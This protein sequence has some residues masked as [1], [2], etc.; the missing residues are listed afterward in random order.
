MPET[1]RIRTASRLHFGLLSFGQTERRQF[2]GVGLMVQRPGLELSA[3]PAEEFS[4]EGPAAER[5][6]AFARQ[7]RASTRVGVS[8]GDVDTPGAGGEVRT[9]TGTG[10]RAAATSAG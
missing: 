5:I 8:G 10:A 3:A 4:V 1:Y 6:W 2:G 9:S 7:W